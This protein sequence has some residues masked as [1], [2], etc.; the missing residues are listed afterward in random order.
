MVAMST[1]SQSRKI[2]RRCR[3]RLGITRPSNHERRTINYG[4]FLFFCSL[5][6]AFRGERGQDARRR[7]DWIG[8][9]M[10]CLC[11][12]ADRQNK[13]TLARSALCPRIQGIVHDGGIFNE[14]RFLIFSISLY[15][16]K[17]ERKVAMVHSALGP[18]LSLYHKG[19]P[20]TWGIHSIQSNKAPA[21]RIY[22]TQ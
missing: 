19:V 9:G 15:V 21:P 4:F 17:E 11:T 14:Y 16:V 6:F 7:G 12:P 3:W 18:I 10:D 8:A 2:R 22:T 5:V 13:P 20:C 1:V